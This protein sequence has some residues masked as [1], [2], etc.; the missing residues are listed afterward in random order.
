[1]LLLQNLDE[2]SMQV[3]SATARHA[4][5]TTQLQAGARRLLEGKDINGNVRSVFC[6]KTG[7]C[8]IVIQSVVAFTLCQQPGHAG[9]KL[10]LDVQ[11][12]MLH[13]KG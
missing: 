10:C 6:N 1:M 12:H 8:I 9:L 5:A 11:P 3:L 7:H 4:A 13:E 2:T